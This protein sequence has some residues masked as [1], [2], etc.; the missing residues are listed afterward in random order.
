ME[1]GSS[2]TNTTEDM[3]REYQITL[4]RKKYLG[5]VQFIG[6]LFKL[7]L[8][9]PDIMIWCLSRLLFHKEEA[10]ED[11]LECFIKLMTVVGEQ[12]EYLVKNG[13]CHA[14]AEEKW[15]QCWD[16]VYFLTG[17]KNTKKRQTDSSKTETT[18]TLSEHEAP[19]PPKISSR[20]KFMLVDL[21]ELEENG[22][23]LCLL[24]SMFRGLI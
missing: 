13:K 19:K 17:R 21:L 2:N 4:I 24:V 3:D 9:K 10:D 16:R 11:D 15:Y 8:I 6:E 22:K 14:V 1:D 7:K 18:N 20:I 12:A 5:H 23:F